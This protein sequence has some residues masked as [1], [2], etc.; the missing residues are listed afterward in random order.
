M[1]ATWV[2]HRS[3]SGCMLSSS[4]RKAWCHIG[5]VTPVLRNGAERMRRVILLLTVMAATLVVASGVA[6]A[7]NKIGTNGPDTLR[8]TNGADNLLGNGGNDVLFGLAGRDTLLGGGG[9]DWLLGGNEVRPQGGHKNLVGG[10]G[11][12]GFF[13]GQGPDNMLGGS[14]NDALMGDHGSDSVVG[15]SGKDIVNG[16]EGGDRVV[17]GEGPD[18]VVSGDVRDTPKNTLS[19]GDGDDALIANNRPAT[20]D[21]VS[22]DGG[23]DLVVA[24]R[25]DL[26]ADDCEKVR[27]GH[28]PEQE[29]DALFVE[30]GFEEVIEGLP[31]DPTA[32][33]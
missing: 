19:G 32:G 20:K 23:S 4:Q 31:P 24:D 33:G 11:N 13:G 5:S 26:V 6:W 22:C 25:K 1:F 30:L 10:S 2:M 27:R 28:T 3:H 16:E 9:K 21:I 8:G 7:V 14:G 18:W 17:G 12:D 15:G 29:I